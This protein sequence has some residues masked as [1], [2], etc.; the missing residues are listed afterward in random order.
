MLLLESSQIL[1]SRTYQVLNN[2]TYVWWDLNLIYFILYKYYYFSVAHGVNGGDLDAET[3]WNMRPGQDGAKV[4]V[5]I[6]LADR[7]VSNL[8]A[9]TDVK[10]QV[11]TAEIEVGILAFKP[12][13]SSRFNRLTCIH[14][15]IT[16]RTI[17]R[18]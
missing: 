11:S 12:I 5:S 13:K 1:D 4:R 15:E 7:G 2:L 14:P 8:M 18:T 10:C 17:F 3:S 9:L 6:I 16:I